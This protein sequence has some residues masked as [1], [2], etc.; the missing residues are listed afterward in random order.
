MSKEFSGLILSESYERAE[1]LRRVRNLI[2]LSRKE[3]CDI[4]GININT[5]IGYEVGRY[6]GLT[7]KG[8]EKII[9]FAT[10]K[11]VFSSLEWLL[12]GNGQP[13]RVITDIQDNFQRKNTSTERDNILDEICLF[14]K[15]YSNVMDYQIIDDGM[16]PIFSIGDYVAG[17]FFTGASIQELIELN[18]IVQLENGEITTRRLYQGIKEDNYTLAC[19]NPLTKVSQP[20]IY[21]AKILFAAKILWHRK[22]NV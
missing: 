18:C 9:A 15:H 4:T 13:P 20:I 3:L 2:N 14:K 5:Y 6:G 8:A 21:D 17:V 19:I 12:H 7:K 10:T 11:G 16:L 1:R 22:M